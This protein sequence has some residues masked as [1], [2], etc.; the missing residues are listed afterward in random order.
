M[1]GRSRVGRA[2]D[3]LDQAAVEAALRAVA[4]TASGSV[5]AFDYCTTEVLESHAQ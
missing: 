3:D 5:V 4:G 1:N 2:D